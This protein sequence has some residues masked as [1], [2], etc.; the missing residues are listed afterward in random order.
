MKKFLSKLYKN[1]RQLFPFLFTAFSF[2]KDSGR[3]SHSHL[4]SP[5]YGMGR[6]LWGC[7]RLGCC[8]RQGVEG[9]WWRLRKWPSCLAPSSGCSGSGRK[10]RIDLLSCLPRPGLITQCLHHLPNKNQLAAHHTAGRGM[11]GA[12]VEGETRLHPPITVS[13]QG[14]IVFQIQFW[15]QGGPPAP[16]WYHLYE[17]ILYRQTLNRLMNNFYSMGKSELLN[18]RMRGEQWASHFM[19]LWLQFV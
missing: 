19:P 16:S 14:F 2:M 17:K 4:F 3:G 10:W 13:S 12:S 8:W 9:E 18:N 15:C 5:S 7:W 1:G 6:W 11:W